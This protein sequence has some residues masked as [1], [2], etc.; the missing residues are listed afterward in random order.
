MMKSALVSCVAL[1]SLS[2]SFSAC[3]FGGKKRPPQ[4]EREYCLLGVAGCICFDPRFEQPPTGTTPIDCGRDLE[5]RAGGV[6]YVRPYEACRNYHA[7]SPEDYDELQAWIRNQC[8]GPRE[9]GR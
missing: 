2:A 9:V 8:W 6:C 5:G 1:L 7:Y 4:P 3:A